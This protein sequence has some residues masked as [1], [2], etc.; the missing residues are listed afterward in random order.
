MGKFLVLKDFSYIFLFNATSG[1]FFYSL[2]AFVYNFYPAPPV[3]TF[4]VQPVRLDTFLIQRE[5][6]Y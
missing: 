2:T 3:N 4:I 6:S 5:S 1:Y